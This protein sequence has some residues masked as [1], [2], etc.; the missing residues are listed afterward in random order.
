MIRISKPDTPPTILRDAGVDARR[1]HSVAF[2][3]NPE[4]FESGERTFDFDR[5]IYAHRTVKSALIDAQHRKCC[6]CESKITH[7][8]YGDVEHFRPKAGYRQD[9]GEELHRPGYYWLAYSWT[10]L[11]L[12]C[13]ICNRRF[14]HNLFPLANPDDR[15]TSHRDDIADEEPM[16]VH[17]GRGDPEVHI[18]FREAVAFA[19]EGSARGGTTIAALQLNRDDLYEVRRDYY[20]ATF[21]EIE[22]LLRFLR[23]GG[24]TDAEEREAHR[25]LRR[26]LDRHERDAL[27]DSKPYA[28]ML[29]DA[30]ARFRDETA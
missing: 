6:F 4:A 29:R 21:K 26:I 3:Y 16:F 30:V 17:P 22:G 15:A 7:V 11:F 19:R 24:L 12:S 27:R 2:A 13:E 8:A 9:P 23:S 18:S 28:S 5:R 10:N 25:H 14:K 20:N 1:S